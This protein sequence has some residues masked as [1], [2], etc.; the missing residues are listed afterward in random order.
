MK[1]SDIN[2]RVTPFKEG[3]RLKVRKRYF[4]DKHYDNKEDYHPARFVYHHGCLMVA[5]VYDDVDR[6]WDVSRVELGWGSVS[7]Q[8]GVN[9]LVEGYGFY[10]ARDAKGGGP[11]II[12]VNGGK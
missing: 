11:R 5:F 8:Q 7:D 1:I 2:P 12:N 4:E 3:K 9:Q 6:R 10:Y